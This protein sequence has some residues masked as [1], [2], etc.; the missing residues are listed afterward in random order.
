MF[1][2]RKIIT[3]ILL[4]NSLLPFHL[5]CSDEASGHSEGSPGK[6]LRVASS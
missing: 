2:L 3:S 6:E 4:A 5:A 1:M